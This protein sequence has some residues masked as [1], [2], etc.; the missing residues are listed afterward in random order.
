VAA[1][2]FVP[3]KAIDDTRI[4]TSPPRRPGSWVP[5]R[6]AE[7]HAGQ[8]RGERLGS[9][10][11]DQGFG[12][13]L[14]EGFRG[15]LNLRPGEHEDDAIAGCLTIALKRASLFGRAPVIHDLTIA[16]TLWGF[17]D[18]SAPDE[19]VA[20]RR[21]LF[22]EVANSHHY[23]EQRQIADRVPESTLRMQPAEVTRRHGED[24]RSLLDLPA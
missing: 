11:P 5:D 10:G 7:L 22:E 4:Y 15:R 24:W 2:R 3:T 13:T 20:L 8:P 17:L 16:F 1:P 23:A 18:E 14:A 6:P 9:P 12:L 19:L 21:T